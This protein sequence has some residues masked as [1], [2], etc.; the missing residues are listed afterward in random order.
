MSSRES[1]P[2]HVGKSANSNSP[3]RV[4][5]QWRAFLRNPFFWILQVIVLITCVLL[6]L[7]FFPKAFP[8]VDLDIK[9]TRKEA[10]KQAS[11]LAQEHHWAP[12]GFRQ[13]TEFSLDSL[14]QNFVELNVG[15]AQAF[16]K[17][18]ADHYYYP[19]TWRVRNFK[20]GQI[21][22]SSVIFTPSGEFYGFNQRI[23]EEEKGPA[24]SVAE[25]RTIAE[26]TVREKW[27]FDLSAFKLIE[28]SQDKK[29]NGRLDHVFIYERPNITLGEGKFRVALEVSGSKLSLF[30]NFVK[31]PESFTRRYQEMRSFNHIISNIATFFIYIFYFGG[32]CIF[33]LYFLGK[34]RWITWKEPL[35]W[36]VSIAALQGIEKINQLPLEWMDYDTALGTREFLLRFFTNASGAFIL[37]AVLLVFSFMAAESLSRKA[38]PQHPQLWKI[39]SKGAGSS[40][41]ILG[42]TL[43]GYLTVGFSIAYV[44]FAYYFATRYLHWWT[45]AETLYQPDSLSSYLPWLTPIANSL[46]AGFWEECLFRA[47]PLAG[48]AL[49]GNRYGHRKK[50]LVA[51]FL[52]QAVI[53]AAGHANYPAQP[54]YARVIELIIPSFIFG[55]IFLV[56]GLLSSIILH[57]TFDVVMFSIPIFSAKVPEIWMDQIAIVLLTLIPLWVV[58]IRRITAGKWTHLT[59]AHLNQGWTPSR[60]ISESSEEKLPSVK[61]ELP[62]KQVLVGV[63]LLAILGIVSLFWVP[64]KNDQPKLEMNRKTAISLAQNELKR[65]GFNL[66]EE[67]QPLASIDSGLSSDDRFVWRTSGEDT[68]R[69]IVSDY[70][71]PPAWSVRFVRFNANVVERAEEFGVRLTNSFIDFKHT[72]PESRPGEKLPESDAYQIALKALLAYQREHYHSDVRDISYL[73][74]ISSSS[75]KLPNRLDWTFTFS[76]TR[77]HL[78]QGDARILVEISGTEPTAVL[79]YVFIPEEWHRTERAEKHTMGIFNTISILIMG[80][81]GIIAMT[82]ALINVSKKNFSKKT[83]LFGFSALVLFQ[84]ISFLNNIPAIEATFG[85]TQPK[86]NQ[87]ANTLLFATVKILSL[88]SISGLFLGYIHHKAKRTKPYSQWH[89]I[90]MGVGGGII[91]VGWLTAINRLIPSLHPTVGNFASLDGYL[92]TLRIFHPVTSYVTLTIGALILALFVQ[93]LTHH[94]TLG[95]RKKILGGVALL[96]VALLVSTVLADKVGQWL[97]LGFAIGSY[98]ILAFHF[99]FKS[100]LS[101]VPL[102]TGVVIAFQSLKQIRLDPYSGSS[103]HNALSV[104]AILVLSFLWFKNLRIKDSGRQPDL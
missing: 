88:S 62:R 5:F 90:W 11:I 40:V 54:S 95:I 17:L 65:R 102:T 28:N 59:Q 55:G 10:L 57:F 67:W 49:L 60:K 80:L 13:T 45:P 89:S 97:L 1:S 15:G 104:L 100:H 46:H 48:A 74:K 73:K 85:T 93:T 68:Y 19:Y 38:F 21:H 83:F 75:K 103:W 56:F 44:V 52:I 34:I 24:L 82:I 7:Q 9:M 35:F 3:F 101:L 37:E 36:G 77:Q 91:A 69:K 26:K 98:L 23:P 42:R 76:D 63:G 70:L 71:S 72:L 99:I 92:P 84:G 64:I 22:E 18:L 66:S 6:S 25:A 29:P 51:A 87:I 81:L 79:P 30:R 2:S 39:W 96:G 47:V 12:E 27:N 53:F 78:K 61:H 43:G 41:E 20:E 32:G 4:K 31:V 14:T 94:W 50:W 8:I 33:G 16:R 58:L 86:Y